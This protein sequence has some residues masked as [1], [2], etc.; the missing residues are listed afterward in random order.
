[1]ADRGSRCCRVSLGENAR[2][3]CPSYE[4]IR[5][6]GGYAR[7]QLFA[8]TSPAIAEFPGATCV[9]CETGIYRTAE[10]PRTWLLR[11][12][13]MGAERERT[14]NKMNMPAFTADASLVN[15]GHDF[16]F[17]ENDLN[18]NRSRVLPQRIKVP[19]RIDDDWA[20][21]TQCLLSG[22]PHCPVPGGGGT[23]PPGLPPGCVYYKTDT[24]CTAV[25]QWCN[26]LC[27]F[28]DGRDGSSGWYVCGACFGFDF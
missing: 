2:K 4:S 23:E 1:M 22:N 20:Q 18:Q 21:Y 3:S 28:P 14:G 12:F 25:V 8:S 9:A 5:S 26:N 10:D 16:R 24:A 15:R 27:Q 19:G 11:K 6:C 7:T 17:H 13:V